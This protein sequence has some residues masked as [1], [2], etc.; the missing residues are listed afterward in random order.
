[1]RDRIRK[2]IDLVKEEFENR[3]NCKVQF[4]EVSSGEVGVEIMITLEVTT[5]EPIYFTSI[6][7]I[8]QLQGQMTIIGFV[9][10]G[11]FDCLMDRVL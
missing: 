9:A 7:Q 3:A 4:I 2:R 6:K 10:A 11:E 8:G 1:M 5:Y